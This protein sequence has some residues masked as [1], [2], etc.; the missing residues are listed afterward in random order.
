M[1]ARRA[2]R[3]G[4]SLLVC[5]RD[6]AGPAGACQGLA[7]GCCALRPGSA[8]WPAASS[9]RWSPP[10][11]SHGHRLLPCRPCCK[12]KTLSVPNRPPPLD[13]PSSSKFLP[14]IDC[15]C[16]TSRPHPPDRTISAQPSQPGTP[17]RSGPAPLLI[18]RSPR[19]FATFLIYPYPEPHRTRP[20]TVALSS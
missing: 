16:L 11:C 2:G 18:S 20:G 6:A 5:G 19:V 8:Q 7:Q 4:I 13:F 17:S 12:F 14:D 15:S 3:D 9:P 1:G 10:I